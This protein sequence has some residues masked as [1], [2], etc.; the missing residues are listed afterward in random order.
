V[1]QH[2]FD[3]YLHDKGYKSILFIDTA[4][5]PE[6]GKEEGD[7]S[8]LQADLQS[9]RDVGYTVDRWSVNGRTQEEIE[10][11]FAQYDVLYMCGGN[12][13][14][15]KRQLVGA[16]SFELIKELV[17]NGKPY[18]S[19]SAGSIIACAKIPGY[20]EEDEDEALEDSSGFGF[21]E[22]I[23]VPHWGQKGHF[24]DL[25]LNKRIQKAYT[26]N[27]PTFLLMSN[28][29]YAVVDNGKIKVENT[30]A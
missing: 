3:N 5:E 17:E 6:V 29:S 16:G 12:T 9:L 23:F 20:L 14:H 10:E 25:Y 26:E 13:N 19:T 28:Y 7:D 11:T 4:A 1:A 18:I 21:A 27:E 22:V 8:W 15:L 30:N 2:I 24:E